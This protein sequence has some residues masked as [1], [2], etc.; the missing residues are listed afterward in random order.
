MRRWTGCRR[1]PSADGVSGVNPPH[2]ATVVL[3]GTV[4][5]RTKRQARAGSAS[6]E[7]WAKTDGECTAREKAQYWEA[8]Q[9][10]QRISHVP[11]RRLAHFFTEKYFEQSRYPEAALRPCFSPYME[12]MD[13]PVM[14]FLTHKKTEKTYCGPKDALVGD[15][16]LR[17]YF[18]DDPEDNIAKWRFSAKR[19][20]M[21]LIFQL[22]LGH[23][24]ER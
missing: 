14:T 5:R 3:I 10:V 2:H 9:I 17:H 24:F 23:L 13:A 21:K 19:R 4:F 22:R 18:T 1:R 15:T 7:G 6:A 16:Q 8:R 20:T 11:L 12:Q